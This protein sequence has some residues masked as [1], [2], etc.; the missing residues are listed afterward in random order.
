MTTTTIFKFRRKFSAFQQHAR[1]EPVEITRHRRL[2][3]VLMSAEHYEWMRAASRRAHRT[4]NTT[5]AVSSTVERAEM[6]PETHCTRRTA[7]VNSLPIF[8]S[9]IAD[10]KTVPEED[11][12]DRRYEISMPR[13]LPAAYGIF[14]PDTI[15]YVVAG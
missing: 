12:T 13:R 15:V 1:R 14:R 8:H 5:T 4:S 7:D 9:S 10:K 11:F 3:F 6:D 2:V